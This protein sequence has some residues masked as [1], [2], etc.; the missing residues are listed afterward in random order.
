MLDTTVPATDGLRGAGDP[1]AID[2][3]L[4]GAVPQPLHEAQIVP[5]AKRTA[6]GMS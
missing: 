6:T 2:P 5:L 4:A 3:P 1:A